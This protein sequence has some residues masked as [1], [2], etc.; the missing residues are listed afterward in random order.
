[1]ELQDALGPLRVRSAVSMSQLVVGGSVKGAVLI[2]NA[3]QEPLRF[4]A[5]ADVGWLC[6]PVTGGVVAGYSGVLAGAPRNIRLAP[7][8][9][10]RLNIIVGATPCRSGGRLPP[11]R[12]EV[13]APVSVTFV[14]DDSAAVPPGR[15]LARGAWVEI[16]R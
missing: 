10:A 6:D 2:Q 16:T 5:D 4:A 13:L 7:N 9:C 3:G 11:G 1:M 12:Y 15:L 8:E 14:G